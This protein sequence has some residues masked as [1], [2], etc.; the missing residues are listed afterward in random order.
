MRVVYSQLLKIF[1]W[2]RCI[3]S[4]YSRCFA[5]V[6][7]GRFI[8][9]EFCR[10]SD[11]QPV[12]RAGRCQLNAPLGTHQHTRRYC[13]LHKTQCDVHKFGELRV[14]VGSSCDVTVSC[15][16]PHVYLDQ[17]LVIVDDVARRLSVSCRNADGLSRVSLSDMKTNKHNGQQSDACDIQ[18]P[19]KYGSL[20][21]F[22]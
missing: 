1:S 19:I 13:S 18:V 10:Q 14:I 11:V 20:C 7:N 16:N 12:A 15:L 22:Y 17:K 4:R 2:P 5:S 8:T 6:C 9:D 3:S 21:V